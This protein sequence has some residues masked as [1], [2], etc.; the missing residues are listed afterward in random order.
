MS[1]IYRLTLCVSSFFV[2]ALSGC[3][4]SNLSG[5]RAAAEPTPFDTV[6][7]NARAVSEATARAAEAEAS[8][9]ISAAEK[10]ADV[11]KVVY[12]S[13]FPDRL[14][15]FE[16]QKRSAG[17]AKRSSNDLADSVVLMGFAKLDEQKA[18]LTIDGIVK[19]LANGEELAGVTVISIEPPRAVL[20]RGRSRWTASIQ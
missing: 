9:A 14:D 11:E 20:Q 4:D 15:M 13:P 6:A 3:G 16:P 19:T 7:A 5:E 17:A 10:K 18:V 8:K 12:Q 1:T 2:L